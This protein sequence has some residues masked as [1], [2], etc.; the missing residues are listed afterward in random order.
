MPGQLNLGLAAVAFISAQNHPI[1]VR[2]LSGSPDDH[3][4]YHYIAHTSLDVIDE[5]I[6][7]APPK[8]PTESYLGFLY[9]LEDVA[10]YG[11]VT[12][13]KLKIVLALALTDAV[14]HDANIIS[15]FKALHWAYYRPQPTLGSPQWMS[16][17]RRVD[18]VARAA[19]ALPVDS[20]S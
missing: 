1:L 10:V 3:L 17:R 8:T 11:Y 19:G 9:A 2:A 4:K 13:L 12:P 20:S 5:R 7:A 6:A 18:E 14:V 15:I 16:F